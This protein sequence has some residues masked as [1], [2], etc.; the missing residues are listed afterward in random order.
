MKAYGSGC[1]DPHFLDLGTSWR[2][3][4]NA[5]ASLLPG[6][7]PP[8]T[9]WIGGWVDLRAGLDD[10]E[11]R[12][13]LTLPGLKLRS[14]DRPADSYSLYRL[15][16]PGSFTCKRLVFYGEALLALRPTPKLE[17]H[18]CPPLLMQYIRSYPPKLE[19]VSSIRNLMTRHAVVTRDP[20]NKRRWPH[21]NQFILGCAWNIDKRSK[22]VTLCLT[23]LYPKI[24]NVY[25]DFR[26]AY[27]SESANN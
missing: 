20:P 23:S 8:G 17:D 25:D 1:R 13:F 3:V 6:K 9:H 11:K 15:R 21:K 7:E 18:P 27:Q 16:Y 24:F 26:Q 19:G 5:P 22:I 4:V 2:W 10:L 12:K 14:H